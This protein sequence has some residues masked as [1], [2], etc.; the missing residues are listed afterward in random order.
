MSRI[1]NLAWVVVVMAATAVA[2]A[3]VGSA[4]PGDPPPPCAYTLSPPQ[5]VQ[6]EGGSRVTAT[7]TV[8]GCAG[9]FR[10][11]YS[12]ACVYVDGQDSQGQCTQ[13][14]GPAPAHVFFEP[15]QPGATY[16]ST[17]RGCGTLFWDAYAPNCQVLGPV[18]ATL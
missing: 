12:V 5:V 11:G 3:G 6:A 7:V 18:T 4:G 2:G 17:G 16:R 9:A 15:Y 13:A 1:V 8:A 10:P 14:R